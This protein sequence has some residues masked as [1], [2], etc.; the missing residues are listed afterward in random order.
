MGGYHPGEIPGVEEGKRQV[1]REKPVKQ[2]ST[3]RRLQLGQNP[4][5]STLPQQELGEGFSQIRT[6]PGWPV[7]AE[8]CS[9]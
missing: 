8:R 1:G 7:S 9:I 5:G 2:V 4:E 3:N 6:L